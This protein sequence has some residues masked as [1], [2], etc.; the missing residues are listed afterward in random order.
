MI[1][2]EGPEVGPYIGKRLGI[3]LN[4]PYTAFGFMTNDKRALAAFA[5]NEFNGSN[6]EVTG[7]VEPAGLTRQVLHYLGEYVF[8]KCQCRRLTMRTKK[9]NK[10]MLQLAPR[11]GFKYEC[12]AKHYF[13]DDDAVVFRMLRDECPWLDVRP[14]LSR[15][16]ARNVG[17]GDTELLAK[18]AQSPLAR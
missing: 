14:S 8:G 3:T 15:N 10:E 7:I 6:I 13:S 2:V 11:L 1:V 5:F 9:R 18:R 17:V 12:V 4:E 16:N